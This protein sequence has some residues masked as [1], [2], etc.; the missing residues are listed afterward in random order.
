MSSGEKTEQP[1]P[2]KVKD[3]RQK[4]QV[5][6]SKDVSSTGMLI[7]VMAFLFIGAGWINDTLRKLIILPGELASEPFE[8]ALPKMLYATG[9][10]IFIICIPLAMLVLVFGIFINY[11]QIGPL[12]VFEP[13]KPEL[14]KLNPVEKA[15]QIVSVKNFIEFLKSSFKVVF[16]GVLLFLVVRSELSNLIEIPYVGLDGA[17]SMLRQI[18]MRV[19]IITVVAY[20][21][22]A[23]FDFVFQ[24]WQHTKQLKMTKDEIK[25]EYKESEGD[26]MIKGKRKQLH[27][28]MVMSGAVENTKKSTVLVT[29]PTHRAIAI[30][31][32]EGDTKLPMIMA[33]GEGVLAKRMIEAAK[34]AGIPIMQNVPLATDLFEH[35]DIEQYIPLELIEPVAEVLR[36]VRELQESMERDPYSEF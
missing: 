4:G 18:L 3:A 30:Y 8:E 25:R 20:I 17:L 13:L 28:E 32:K 2:K 23:A 33:K 36:W 24:Q 12:F 14:K 9:H 29:N 11:I 10:A 7:V 31:Y 6:Q 21:I 15:K 35:G 22:V 34:E 26:P 1:T 16:L 5:A 27:Q 19:T